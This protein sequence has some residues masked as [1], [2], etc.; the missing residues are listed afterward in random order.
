M[1]TIQANNLK[2]ALENGL[3]IDV[4]TPAE[5][6]EMH[7]PGSQLHPLDR[8]DHSAIRQL[9]ETGPVY[10]LCRSGNRATQAIRDLEKGGIENLHLVEGGITACET[11]GL[12][13]NRGKKVM[14]LERQ[15]RIAAGALIVIGVLIGFFAHPAGFG[16]SAFVGA[17]LMFAGI[18]DSCAMGMLIAKMP[19]NQRSA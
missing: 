19:W 8:L 5:Y 15:V 1:N 11:E 7:I 16:L 12:E 2:S 13:M 10:V 18:T 4:R 9:S 17:G 3:L 6:G 14:S